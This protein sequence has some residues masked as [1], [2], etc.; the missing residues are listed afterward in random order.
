MIVTLN[1]AEQ[2]LARAIAEARMTSAAAAGSKDMTQGKLPPEV[3]DLEGAGAEVAF[4]KIANVWPD[5]EPGAKAVDAWTRIGIAV[6]VK[7]TWREDGR[8]L[9][10]RWKKSGEV[11][12]YVLMIGKFPTFKCVGFMPAE[13]LISNERLRNLGNGPTYTADQNELDRIELLL[14]D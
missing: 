8:L 2:A 11:A 12:A 9:A 13:K 1:E 3:M 5:T 4:C 6:D 14:G 7:S 10:G